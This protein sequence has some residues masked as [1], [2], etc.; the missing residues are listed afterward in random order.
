MHFFVLYEIFRL[1][2]TKLM[3]TSPHR[4]V[5]SANSTHDTDILSGWSMHSKMINVLRE[6]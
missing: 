3:G 2:I 5:L 4:S 1:L 6:R